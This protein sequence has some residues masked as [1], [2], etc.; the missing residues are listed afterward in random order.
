MQPSVLDLLAKG[1]PRPR[2]Q[3]QCSARAFERHCLCAVVVVVWCCWFQWCCGMMWGAPPFDVDAGGGAR[4]RW[5]SHLR[6][7]D[8]CWR[9]PCLM[10][11]LCVMTH[12]VLGDQEWFGVRLRKTHIPLTRTP[13]ADWGGKIAELAASA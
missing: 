6:G 4:G 1:G 2:V 13:P 9:I 7:R 3:Q 11:S 12:D 10:R 5:S 8:H